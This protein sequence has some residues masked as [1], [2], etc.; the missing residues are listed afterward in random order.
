M[1][2]QRKNI[3]SELQAAVFQRLN[4][5]TPLQDELG[6]DR[7]YDIV[8]DKEVFPYLVIGE[9]DI[10]RF[11]THDFYGFKGSVTIYV[12]DQSQGRSGY[13]KLK[14][15]MSHVYEAL[16]D[17]DLGIPNR[18]QLEFAF[19]RQSVRT[20]DDNKTLEGT[21]EFT[22]TFGGFNHE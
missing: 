13:R 14:G 7:I 6:A 12:Y 9:D 16:H 19:S 4:S 15:I 8:P 5:H 10:D 18:K 22:F 20:E 11:D 1:A 2:D 17:V 3:I 21:I